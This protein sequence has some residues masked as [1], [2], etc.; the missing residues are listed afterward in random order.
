V[1]TK[2]LRLLLRTQLLLTPLWLIPLLLIPL[3]LT[4]LL[5]SNQKA[6][7]EKREKNDRWASGLAVFLLYMHY[8]ITINQY[9]LTINH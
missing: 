3:L 2:Q 7:I 9:P 6:R 4:Q 5:L 1:V 8:P